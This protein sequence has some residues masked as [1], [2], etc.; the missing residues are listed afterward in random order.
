MGDELTVSLAEE[1]KALRVWKE[2][3]CAVGDQELVVS[4][5]CI[6]ESRDMIGE[7][8]MDEND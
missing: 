2:G 3:H 4:P 6:R 1:E 5:W 7:G 8:I